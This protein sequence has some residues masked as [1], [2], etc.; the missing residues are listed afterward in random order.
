MRSLR[1]LNG[2]LTCIAVLLTLNLATLWLSGGPNVATVA[3]ADTVG[4]P[5]AGTQRNQIVMAM[6]DLGDKMD[7]LNAQF[8]SGQARV[9]VENLDEKSKDKNNK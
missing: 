9:R 4:F 3:H 5:D 7:Q 8:R 2:V 6:R 1:Y